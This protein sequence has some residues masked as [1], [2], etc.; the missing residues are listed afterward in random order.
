M[1]TGA[2]LEDLALELFE[3]FWL[4]ARRD[5][6][7]QAQQTEH[8]PQGRFLV[9]QLPD[10]ELLRWEVDASDQVCHEAGERAIRADEQGEAHFAAPR[11]RR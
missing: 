8:G 2:H 3:H 7:V 9:D 10:R 1:A 6:A 4:E 11:A 5:D